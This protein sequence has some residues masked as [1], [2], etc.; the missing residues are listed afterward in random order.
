MTTSVRVLL[1]GIALAAIGVASPAVAQLELGTW[2]RKASDQ[3][4][5]MTMTIEA[6]CD[7][8]RKLTYHVKTNNTD[9]LIVIETR[10]DGADAP[11]VIAGQRSAETMAIK[12]DDDHH[13]TT[14]IRFNGAVI[15]TAKATLSQDGKTLTNLL[16]YTKADAGVPPG[17]YTEVWTKK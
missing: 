16:E 2:V 11:V 13:A 14:V 9:A 3:M 7:G 8:G 10:L 6:C 12:R 17:K 1:C 5:E 15:G 4:P